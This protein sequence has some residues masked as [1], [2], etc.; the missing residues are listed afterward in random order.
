MPVHN[1]SLHF[2]YALYTRDITV[3]LFTLSENN[4]NSE[5]IRIVSIQS[6]STLQLKGEVVP[7]HATK[8]GNGSRLT[9]PLI[10][11]LSARWRQVVNFTPRPHYSPGNN[12]GTY[13]TEGCVGPKSWSGRSGEEKSLLLLP[14]QFTFNGSK[15]NTCKL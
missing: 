10:L 5:C 13:R 1:I 11:N 2:K 9:A 7:V 15:V 4:K 3:L 12:H 6:D 14:S 8:A